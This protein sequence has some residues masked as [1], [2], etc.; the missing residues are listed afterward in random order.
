MSYTYVYICIKHTIINTNCLIYVYSI[1]I[2]YSQRACVC[3][4][5]QIAVSHGSRASNQGMGQLYAIQKR[6][7]RDFEA[8]KLWNTFS[9]DFH[10]PILS[11]PPPPLFILLVEKKR[12]ERKT[13]PALCMH[14]W[15][16]W[17]SHSRSRERCLLKKNGIEKGKEAP[18]D[19][20]FHNFS[21]SW[22][23]FFIYSSRT[24]CDGL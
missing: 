18:P 15:L 11:R 3:F 24:W 12:E 5:S 6:R 9:R 19:K 16:G 22:T 13:Q 2:H 17:Q 14:A 23:Y 7:S 4:E 20:P 8:L 10:R 1:L 21:A